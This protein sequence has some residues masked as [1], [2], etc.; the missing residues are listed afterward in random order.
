M[1]PPLPEDKRAGFT[2]LVVALIV[3]FAA[4]YGVVQLTNRQF[5]SHTEA[6]ESK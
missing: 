6:A 2:G 5:A 4:I 1:A 3:L